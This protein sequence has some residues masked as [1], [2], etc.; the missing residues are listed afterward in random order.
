M[1]LGK[2]LMLTLRFGQVFLKLALRR[3]G[4]NH[5][6]IMETKIRGV[7]QNLKI[8]IFAAYELVKCSRFD[9]YYIIMYAC[10]VILYVLACIILYNII[11]IYSYKS[12]VDYTADSID[13]YYY[14]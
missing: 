2:Q 11:F 13:I 6:I 10:D 14:N 3:I 9:K 1:Y 7:K 5:V 12:H 8:C 4:L